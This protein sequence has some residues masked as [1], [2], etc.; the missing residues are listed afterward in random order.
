MKD[1]FVGGCCGSCD[2]GIDGRFEVLFHD[3]EVIFR[4]GDGA[5]RCVYDPAHHCHGHAGH[6][7]ELDEQNHI[8]EGEVSV[9][10]SVEENEVNSEENNVHCAAAEGVHEVPEG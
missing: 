10:S 8:A 7:D 1:W 4:P 9:E 2:V 5:L 6:V 3:L